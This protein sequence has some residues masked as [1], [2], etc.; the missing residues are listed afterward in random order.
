[1]AARKHSGSSRKNA[2]PRSGVDPAFRRFMVAATRAPA[3]TD[4]NFTDSELCDR[5]IE[6][7]RP[8][9][10]TGARRDRAHWVNALRCAL[11]S[12]HRFERMSG[13]LAL[14]RVYH[15]LVRDRDAD[16]R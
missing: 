9:D 15:E 13:E 14:L 2:S 3:A 4:R 1:M 6:L 10:P 12:E 5:A 8:I 7:A 11:L 16:A